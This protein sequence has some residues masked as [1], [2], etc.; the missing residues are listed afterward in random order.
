MFDSR[1]SGIFLHPTS[2]PSRWGVGDLGDEA[3]HFVNFLS[4]NYQ[5]VWQ[6]LPISPTR[7]EHSPYS[8]YSSLAGNPILI[9]LEKLQ[10]EGLLNK[11]DLNDSPQFSVER[12]DYDKAIAIKIPLLKLA[13]ENFFD[14]ALPSQKQKFQEFCKTQAYWLDDYALFMAIKEDREGASWNKWPSAIA[15]RLPEAIDTWTKRLK[16]AVYYHKFL[17]FQFFTQWKNLKQY[18]NNL[19]ISIFGDI[20]FYVAHDSVDVWANQE[21]FCLDEEGEPS[22]MAGVP[23]D[24][25]SATGQLWGNPVYN[26]EALEKTNFAWWVQ[27]ITGMLD[28]VDLFRIDH[29]RGMQAFWAVEKGERTAENGKWLEASGEKLFEL[30]EEKIGKLPI[31]AEDLGTVTPQ[32]E[33]L[34]DKFNFPGMK[35]LQFAFDS[36]GG[37]PKFLPHNFDSRNCIVYTGTHD[38]DTILGWFEARSPQEK[39]KIFDYLGCICPQDIHWSF[40]RM[41]MSSIANFA[42]FPFQDILGLGSEAKMN[43]PGVAE[44]NWSWRYNP[45][46]L[47]PNLGKRLKHLT[48][49]YDRLPSK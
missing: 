44:C 11:K 36:K 18:A 31:I 1:V 4:E 2:L 8:S 42:I 47:S 43:T 16:D 17:Q 9:S 35:I 32:V 41:A 33:A 19:G 3:Y 12:V 40:I 13:S 46:A 22:L 23:P 49:V 39:A 24:Y 15:Q 26:W 34:R 29:F 5:Q 30:L 25:F 45:Q 14:Q 6:I 37:E 7:N 28:Y 27:R 48:C 38:N 10:E 21:I 20:S